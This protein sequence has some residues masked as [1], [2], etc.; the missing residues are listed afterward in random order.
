MSLSRRVG[1]STLWQLGGRLVTSTLA[2]AITALMLPRLLDAAALGVFAFH[3]ALYQMLTNVL[4]F[5]AGTIVVR[6]A[7]RDRARAGHLLGLLVGLKARIAALGVL[8]AVAVA[9]CFEG[10]TP[11]AALLCLAALHLLFHAPSGAAAIFVV[12]MVFS[13]AAAV[14]VA[15]QATWLAGTV[16]LALLGVREP[17]LYLL[18]FGAGIA[19][20]GALAW[21]WARRRVALRFD[22]TAAER[23]ALWSEAWPAGV[24]MAAAT[25]YFYV[26][27][28]M[29]RPLAGEEAVAQYSNPYRLM[30]FVLMVPVLFSQVIL[31]VYARLWSA[32]RESLR[33]FYVRTTRFLL[34]IGAPVSA[35]VWLVS[36]DV[37]RLVFPPAYEAGAPALAILSLAAVCVFCAYPHVMLLLAAGEQRLMMRISLLGAALN[38]LVNLWAIPRWGIEG[39]A[40]TTLA[41]EAFVLVA[42]ATGAARRT[43]LRFPLAAAFRPLVCAGG[44]AGALAALLPHLPEVPAVRVGAGL[45]AGAAGVLASGVLPPDFG[46]EQGAPVDLA[47]GPAA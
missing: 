11:R 46:T 42:S 34:A 23:A 24:S 37:M 18:A 41:T 25:L 5:G 38:V 28:I 1:L 7:A 45:L 30:T 6:E 10:G 14:A 15:G 29:L 21:W 20:Q 43:G 27:S 22:A 40:A 44:A 31:P 2:F 36:R 13:R 39:A 16:L 35:T 19:A 26:D 9:L 3:L 8:L 47:T 17:A 4:D 33:P 32:G 12:D